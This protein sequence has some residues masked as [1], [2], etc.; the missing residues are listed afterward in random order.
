M[1]RAGR[2]LGVHMR[3]RTRGIH[4][5][6][7]GKFEHF[8]ICFKVRIFRLRSVPIS[9]YMSTA[10]EIVMCPPTDVTIGGK[11]SR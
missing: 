8:C 11:G 10:D 6:A 5:P 9:E 4:A 1:I 3:I 7:V 2:G